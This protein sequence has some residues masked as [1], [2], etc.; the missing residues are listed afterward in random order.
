MGMGNREEMQSDRNKDLPGSALSVTVI[1]YLTHSQKV[2]RRKVK[3]K[4]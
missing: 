4:R 3:G 2:E 1:S